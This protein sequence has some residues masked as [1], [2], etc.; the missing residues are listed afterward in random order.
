MDTSFEPLD[1]FEALFEAPKAR[2]CLGDGAAID[3]RPAGLG[4]HFHLRHLEDQWRTGDVEAFAQW[5]KVGGCSSPEDLTLEDVSSLVR[6]IKDVNGIKGKPAWLVFG[7]TEGPAR[8]RYSDYPGRALA[9]IVD[10]L[11]SHYNWSLADIINMPVRAAL[12]HVQ[13]CLL[14]DHRDR[15]W[16]YSLSEMAWE[17]DKGSGKSRLRPMKPIPWDRAI[18][19]TE[20]SPVPQDIIDKY[21]PKGNVIDLTRPPNDE[22][23][24][25]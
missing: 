25:T 7:S 2:V 20:Y 23:S 3:L 6:A 11:A 8:E 5:L 12:L 24:S 9:R 15:E 1:Y 10:I 19:A 18:G 22:D 13:E 21:Y 17:Y 16:Q 4:R 14:R